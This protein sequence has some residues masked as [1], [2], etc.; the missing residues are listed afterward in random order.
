MS[1]S[2]TII[3]VLRRLRRRIRTNRLL[4]AAVD[5]FAVVLGAAVVFRLWNALLPV[6]LGIPWT[7][8]ALVVA[9][10]VGWQGRRWFDREPLWQ[11]ART[12]DCEADLHDE[13]LSAYWFVKHAD[14][15][16]G[17]QAGWVDLHLDRAVDTARTLDP[18]EVVPLRRPNRAAVPAVFAAV[19]LVL[20]FWQVP[21]L[22]E[23][24]GDVLPD[25]GQ[26][27][28]DLSQEPIAELQELAEPPQPEE[29]EDATEE[30]E[31]LSPLLEEQQQEGMDA[32]PEEGEGDPESEEVE[33]SF[34]EE[35]EE[36]GQQGE[37]GEQQG[38]GESMEV[39]NPEDLPE[40]SEG[41]EATPDPNASQQQ[42]QGE[43]TEEQGAML[44]GGEEVFLQE[45][46]ED[47]ERS[48]AAE[49]E[50][51]HATREGGEEQELDP[52][53]LETLDVQLQREILAVPEEEETGED[54]EKEEEITRAETSRLDFL[55]VAARRSFSPQD[56]LHAEPIPWRY[57]NLVLTYFKLL[58]ER[59]NQRK[60]ERE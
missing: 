8:Q 20:G 24:I 3:R 2:Q 6:S 10:L 34:M 54:E 49:E 58:R 40:N 27:A 36:G 32:M 50:L 13:L 25:L 22:L 31:V 44:P 28:D 29:P 38:D 35:G 7:I 41:Q 45:G 51:G 59:D 11:A 17:E 18:A 39:Q 55:D 46:G 48:Q 14:A 1:D 23:D 5:L 53:E 52:G 33:G 16:T 43:P 42:G 19:L 21:R 57:S 4:Q 30:R 37:E 12:A 60:E 15:Q 47:L 56:L 9:G 26:S